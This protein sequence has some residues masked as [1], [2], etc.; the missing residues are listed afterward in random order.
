MKAV[1]LEG[2]MIVPVRDDRG[3]FFA[4]VNGDRAA[5]AD[6]RLADV[7][8]EGA[9]LGLAG[10]G[11]DMLDDEAA[12]LGFDG[13]GGGG[14]RAAE[15]DR[16][17]VIA[18]RDIDGEDGGRGAGGVGR[19]EV[20]E[21]L[22]WVIGGGTGDLREAGRGL[23][24]EGEFPLVRLCRA[25]D[26]ER[27]GGAKGEVAGKERA[28]GIQGREGGSLTVSRE[29]FFEGRSGDET[30]G[31]QNPKSRLKVNVF[32]IGNEWLKG[33][34]VA[35]RLRV[36]PVGRREFRRGRQFVKR[37]GFAAKTIARPGGNRD[38]RGEI[39]SQ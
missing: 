26:A 5:G 14:G 29:R 20:A 30:R 23:L 18:L 3:A 27:E 19:H 33:S 32:L 2:E 38:A 17:V 25:G 16:D 1:E 11:L 35:K 24:A 15:C 37:P 21:A 8:G 4:A 12:L 36:N 13:G 7:Y 34:A 28:M 22:R 6:G 31:A 10:G 39:P 9:G